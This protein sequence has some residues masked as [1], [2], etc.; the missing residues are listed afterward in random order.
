M[1]E[2]AVVGLL[3]ALAAAMVIPEMAEVSQDPETGISR[4]C[5]FVTMRSIFEA[6]YAI[7]ALDGSVSP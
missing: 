1:K 4:G 3:S 7:T 6:K 5:G 2:Q